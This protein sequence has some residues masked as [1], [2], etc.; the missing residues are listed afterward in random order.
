MADA[1]KIADATLRL[2]AQALHKHPVDDEPNRMMAVYAVLCAV[3][4]PNLAAKQDHLEVECETLAALLKR[5][6][7][8][9][10]KQGAQLQAIRSTAYAAINPANWQTKPNDSAARLRHYQKV[11]DEIASGEEEQAA[12]RFFEELFARMT[13][14]EEQCDR[15]RAILEDWER[16]P[17]NERDA[18]WWHQWETKRREVLDA[19][20]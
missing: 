5:E 15:M 1:I 17:G 14:A 4:Y 6:Q 2:G 20:A 16:T 11:L 8:D 9:F 19:A 7:A 3:G 13:E 10:E 18:A 12:N